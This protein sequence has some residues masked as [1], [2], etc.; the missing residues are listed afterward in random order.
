MSSKYQFERIVTMSPAF[1]RRSSDPKKNFGIHG[2]ELRMVLKGPLGATQFLVFTNWMLPHVT[3]ETFAN[4][5]GDPYRLKLFT[6][7][8]PVDLGYHWH[9]PRYENQGSMDCDLMP[10]GKCYY[11]GSGLNAEPVFQILLSE[12]S[13]GVW[14]KLEEYYRELAANE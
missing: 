3:E 7:P 8:T 11:D 1:D 10:S 5:S 4:H 9:K 12:G 2:V 13:Q 14:K 6:Q